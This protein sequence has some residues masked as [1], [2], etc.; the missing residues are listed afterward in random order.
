M[1]L[2]WHHCKKHLLKALLFNA[3]LT[4]R[5]LDGWQGI[6]YAVARVFWLVA[7]WL[8]TSQSQKGLPPSYSSI[9]IGFQWHCCENLSESLFSRLQM[10]AYWPI[11]KETNSSKL[12]FCSQNMV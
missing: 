5:V 1:V 12:I 4:S 11:L 9:L 2:L 6:A 3:K 8:L 7:K 10:V